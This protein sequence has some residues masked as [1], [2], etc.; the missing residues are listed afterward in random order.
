MPNAREITCTVKSKVWLTPTVFSLS[1]EPSRRFKF[2]AGQF[3]SIVVPLPFVPPGSGSRLRRIYSFACGPGQGYELCVKQ[4]QGPGTS[5]LASLKPGDVFGATAPYGDFVHEPRAERGVCLVSTGT[6]I[7]P[8]RSMMFSERFWDEPP[9]QCLSLFGAS[10][11]QE[12]IYP[13]GFSHIGVQTVNALSKAG[14]DWTGF[15]GRVTDFLAS[16]P[17]DWGW[18]TTDFY[19]CG[20]GEMVRSVA[21]L[22]RSRGVAPTAI[23]QEA[24]FG[25]APAAVNSLPASVPDASAAKRKAA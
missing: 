20:N 21:A 18:T 23:H 3:L 6:G 14:P 17:P 7:A 22:L 10:T 5:Y 8:F 4:T 24:Y 19:M 9:T 15:R 1:F 2:E 12:I 13:E 25:K 16:L 11:E